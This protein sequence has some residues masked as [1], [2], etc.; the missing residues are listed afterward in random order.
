MWFIEGAGW[1]VFFRAPHSPS[2]SL[3]G[4][5][6]SLFL[7]AVLR[8]LECSTRPEMKTKNSLTLLSRVSSLPHHQFNSTFVI[9]QFSLLTPVKHKFDIRERSRFW[10]Q[11]SSWWESW[12]LLLSLCV[13]K[14]LLQ[15]FV[16]GFRLLS[17]TNFSHLSSVAVC[18]IFPLCWGWAVKLIRKFLISCL[19]LIINLISWFSARIVMMMSRKWEIWLSENRCCLPSGK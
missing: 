5:E 8:L 14:N 12:M 15:N 7:F 4:D 13:K 17:A 10:A 6:K 3:W 11:S 2:L 1:F 16:G 18:V 9:F 19:T